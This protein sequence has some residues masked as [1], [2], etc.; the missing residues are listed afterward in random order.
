MNSRS[1]SYLLIA[2]SATIFL[3]TFVAPFVYFFVISFWT[4]DIFGLIPDMTLLNY[5][6][7]YS[8]YLPSLGFTVMLAAGTALLTVIVGFVYAFAARFKFSRWAD[9]LIFIVLVTMFGGYLMKIYAWRT[10]LGN[11]GMLNSAL[12]SAGIIKTPITALLYS[13]GAVIVTL[14]HFGLPFAILP[15]FASLRG[16][17]DI[18]IEVATDLGASS[19]KVFSTIILPRCRPG[20]VTA[21]SFS[22][23]IAIGDY[24]TPM[25]VGGKQTMLGSLIA[26]QFGSTFNWPLGSAM[27]FVLLGVSVL[28]I[29]LFDRTLSLWCRI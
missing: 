7:F 26:P 3:A 20:V 18:E 19:V 27:S 8:R 16:V 14:V 22:F 28:L 4:N 6:E 12:L 15:I 5:R 2:P 13:P 21:F 9:L 23:L 1:L 10:I 11:E 24:V 17:R 29:W 25:L